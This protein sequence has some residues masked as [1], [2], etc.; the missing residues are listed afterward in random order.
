[1]QIK[2][3]QTEKILNSLL[4]KL[5]RKN[6][7]VSDDTALLLKT[8]IDN[9]IEYNARYAKNATEASQDIQETM[10]ILLGLKAH[11]DD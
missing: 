8:Q 9:G 3:K 1:M 2:H 11:K 5:A 6:R 4:A 10:E 7:H